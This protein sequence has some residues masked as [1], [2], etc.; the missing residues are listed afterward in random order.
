MAQPPVSIIITPR[1]RYAWTRP[2]VLSVLDGLDKSIEVIFVAG[3]A[4]PEVLTFLQTL[5][6][7]R[8]K[9]AVVRTDRYLRANEARNLGLGKIKK[10]NDV[11][12]IEN[13]VIV[14]KGWLKNMVR[15]SRAS[16]ADIVSPLIY[17]GEPSD[18]DPQCHIAGAYFIREG[19]GKN[20]RIT[21]MEH[22]LDHQRPQES[23]LHA[24]VFDVVEFHCLWI[25]RKFLDQVSL[26]SNYSGLFAH[27]DL[28]LRAGEKGAKIVVEPKARVFFAN[29][30]IVPI[31]TREDFQFLIFQWN[32]RECLE[33]VRDMR[34]DWG[35][36]FGKKLFWG[37]QDWTR[38]YKG[39][40]FASFGILGAAERF[41]YRMSR[42]SAF[43]GW[44]RKG[45]EDYLTAK[46][47]RRFKWERFVI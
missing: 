33:R 20:G 14:K 10:G 16:G 30:V 44:A 9:F 40:I 39:M 31:K 32:E 26:K 4:P 25:R 35:M 12:F 43:P 1:E 17:E 24:R 19:P 46:I 11:V 36:I 28:C 45:L 42:F 41:F 27:L 5:K 2:S 6:K 34:K 13:D 7:K 8:P 37:Y 22:I 21:G 3:N 23:L 47:E 29:P 18:P 15:C 38:Y